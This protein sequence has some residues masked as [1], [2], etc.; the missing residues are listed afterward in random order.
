MNFASEQ[1]RMPKDEFI[2]MK[3]LTR[4]KE[5]RRE[6]PKKPQPDLGWMLDLLQVAR[7]HEATYGAPQ[8]FERD[9]TRMG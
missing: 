1:P 9:Q 6:Q 5:L 3:M 2:A 8:H 7:H 4:F